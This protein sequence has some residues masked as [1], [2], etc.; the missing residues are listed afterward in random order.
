MPFLNLINEPQPL[1]GVGAPPEATLFSVIEH[2]TNIQPIGVFG[3]PAQDGN[4]LDESVFD[5]NGRPQVSPK[6]S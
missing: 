6:P 2:Y 5:E 3:V 1:A 4:A